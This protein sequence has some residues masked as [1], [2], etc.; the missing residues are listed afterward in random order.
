MQITDSTKLI[1]PI[2][3]KFFKG[4]ICFAAALM[5]ALSAFLLYISKIN[6]PRQ[7]SEDFWLPAALM[8]TLTVM[9]IWFAYSS[10]R[11][12]IVIDNGRIA[13]GYFSRHSVYIDDIIGITDVRSV[14]TLH[15]EQ[16]VIL[17]FSDR[18]DKTHA[19]T[20]NSTQGKEFLDSMIE[21][22]GK[23]D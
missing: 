8:A 14:S 20:A 21:T 13:W 19:I 12:K 7:G 3:G 22:F 5:T 16:F 9:C 2:Y 11:N 1:I 23:P 15:G 10:L 17:R 4:T 18:K 6:G